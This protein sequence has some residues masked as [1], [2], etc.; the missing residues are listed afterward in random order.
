MPQISG[1]CAIKCNRD[2]GSRSLGSERSSDENGRITAV[3]THRPSSAINLDGRPSPI[4]MGSV[5]HEI[6]VGRSLLLLASAFAIPE[7]GAYSEL[8]LGRE[9][10][11]VAATT[12]HEDL[13]IQ[14]DLVAKEG[15][16]SIGGKVMGDV[17][18]RTVEILAPGVVKG[19]ISAEEVKI[20]GRLEGSVKCNALSLEEKSVLKADVTA[21]T[22][23][24]SSG[25]TISGRVEARGG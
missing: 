8:G 17:S 23:T 14:G 3:R 5:G 2:D 19:G 12:I 4:C 9:D 25:A 1:S 18:A 16:I 21:R 13:T 11:A 6:V 15:D 10:R 7:I 24:M 22:M 20:A